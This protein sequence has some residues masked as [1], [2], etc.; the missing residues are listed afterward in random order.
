MKKIIIGSLAVMGGFIAYSVTFDAFYQTWHSYEDVSHLYW[1]FGGAIG[2]LL[3]PLVI[4]L[5]KAHGFSNGWLKVYLS[6][7]YHSAIRVNVIMFLICVC[8]FIYIV[9]NS[10]DIGGSGG[11]IYAVEPKK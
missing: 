3:T 8:I 10:I 2:L 7:Y 11:K 5:I 9:S 1:F 6:S 4:A